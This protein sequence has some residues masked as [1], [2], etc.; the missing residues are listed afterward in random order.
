M[1]KMSGYYAGGFYINNVQVPGSVLVSHDMYFMWR[2]RRISEVTPDSLMLLEVLKPAPE[3]LVLGTGATPQKL[4]PA[5]REYLQRLG[6]RVEVLDSRNATGYFNVLND[7]GR[8]VVGALLVADPEA[9]MPENLPDAQEPL[10]DRA[11]LMQRS[12]TI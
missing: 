11:P 8:A 3:V 2:P 10:W 12:G 9:R 5:V 1:S 7:E 6:M 4:P